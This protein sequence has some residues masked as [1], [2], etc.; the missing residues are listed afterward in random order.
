MNDLITPGLSQLP[1]L[2]VEEVKQ[3]V[4]KVGAYVDALAA[5]K[6]ATTDQ[7]TIRLT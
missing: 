3:T 7:N 4:D 6:K 1:A 2:P 5:A